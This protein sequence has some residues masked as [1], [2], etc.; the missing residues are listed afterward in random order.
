M[1]RSSGMGGHL[2]GTCNA[3]VLFPFVLHD[4]K[5]SVHMI[6]AFDGISFWQVIVKHATSV[7]ICD[8]ELPESR[9]HART[10]GVQH[11]GCS[12]LRMA[13]QA[14]VQ[15]QRQGRLLQLQTRFYLFDQQANR[16]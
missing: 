11:R 16:S 5:N 2:A 8:M 15:S 14:C 1:I 12:L 7:R 10:S 9:F 13:S 4:P 6:Q 3:S